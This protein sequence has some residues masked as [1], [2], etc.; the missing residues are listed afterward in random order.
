MG[1]SQIQVPVKDVRTDKETGR[2]WGPMMVQVM[3]QHFPLGK[4]PFKQCKLFANTSSHCL[5]LHKVFSNAQIL[6]FSWWV[7]LFKATKKHTFMNDFFSP[8]SANIQI[9]IHQV[10]LLLQSRKRLKSVDM[11]KLDKELPQAAAVRWSQHRRIRWVSDNGLKAFSRQPVC[12]WLASSKSWACKCT[13]FVVMAVVSKLFHAI[14][15]QTGQLCS[16]RGDHLRCLVGTTTDKNLGVQQEYDMQLDECR[17]PREDKKSFIWGS[18]LD[19]Y[20]C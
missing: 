11:S 2:R 15:H 4:L 19:Q 13:E 5:T 8:S 12:D 18:G 10:H 6:T 17:K 14:A 7:S 16:H 3:S 9:Q 20:A 1:S